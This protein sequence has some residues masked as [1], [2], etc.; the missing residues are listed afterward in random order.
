MSR[1]CGWGPILLPWQW[2]V[3]FVSPQT[4]RP[5]LPLP[6][7]LSPASS[8]GQEIGWLDSDCSLCWGLDASLVCT[9]PTLCHTGATCQKE[10]VGTG[11]A[12]PM[13]QGQWLPSCTPSSS[14]AP[15]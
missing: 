13:T 5:I 2:A 14:P 8:V 9:T 1:V 12:V 11:G 6:T 15:P 4:L 3:R 7:P 10:E